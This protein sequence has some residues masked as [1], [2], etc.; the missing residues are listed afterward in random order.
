M[1]GKR[2]LFVALSLEILLVAATSAVAAVVHQTT[3]CAKNPTI[4]G[5]VDTHALPPVKN[6][7][8]CTNRFTMTDDALKRTGGPYVSRAEVVRRAIGTTHPTRVGSYFV[9]F[10]D[11]VKMIDLGVE[12]PKIYPDREVWL[13]VVQAEVEDYNFISLPY[14]VDP[15]PIHW[16]FN[17]YDA[18]TG[19]VLHFGANTRGSNTWPAGLALPSPFPTPI[20]PPYP[21]P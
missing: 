17:I 11:A 15:W 5:P 4:G 16:Y 12:D 8:P 10:G 20:R 14:G 9:P 18:T 6:F 13:V 2:L 7:D 19:R 3:P 21:E 1:F